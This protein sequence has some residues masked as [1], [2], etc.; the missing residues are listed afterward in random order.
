MG[1]QYQQQVLYYEIL[2]YKLH[3][4]KTY[5]IQFYFFPTC[6]QIYT[7]RS[8]SH[9]THLREYE[10]IVVANIKLHPR[11]EEKLTTHIYLY[12]YSSDTSFPP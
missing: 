2:K 3:M 10:R 7:S 9:F 5:V 4:G 11:M 1:I 8:H 6:I 12:I